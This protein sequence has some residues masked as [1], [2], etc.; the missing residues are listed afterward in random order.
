MHSFNI[1]PVKLIKALSMALE[2]AVNGMSSH[3][4]RTALISDRIAKQ[5][6]LNAMEHQRLLYAAL[7]HDIGA[8]S[9]WSE[10]RKIMETT[11]QGMH[12]HAEDGYLLLK[13]S[14]QLGD[15]AEPIRYHHDRWA[16]GNYS[17][18][19][20][21]KIPLISRI[22]HIADRV[23]VL[24]RHDEFIFNQSKHILEVIEKS[25]GI[26]FDPTLVAAVQEIA[27][28]ESFWLDLVNP[29]YYEV[30]FRSL[31]VYGAICY[32]LD[33]AI[34]IAEIFATIIDRMSSF[35]A[36][37]SHN[38][39]RIAAFLAKVK[40][41]S[42]D[43]VKNMKIAGLLHDLGKLAIPN[44]ILEKPGQLNKE[45]VVII[46]QHTYYTYRILQEI[47]GFDTIAKWAA[48]HHETLDGKGY[49]FRI[50]ADSLPLGSRILAVADI[51]VALTENRPYRDS[52]PEVRVR[53]IMTEMVAKGKIDQLVVDN[54][55]ASYQEALAIMHDEK[56]I[57]I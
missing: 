44:N 33:D 6:N 18:L 55:F 24:I 41:F 29:N 28:K 51:F 46:R 4:W 22:I 23:E 42:A 25:S 11:N 5:I 35:T 43:E 54:L 21:E 15:L 20:E 53:A 34:N 36:T 37:H 30:F 52:L 26:E 12:R 39:A 10:R 32:S 19:K 50:A 13:D 7:L 8:A 16:G 57:A 49:P 2:L 40:G 56:A 14:I 1:H 17:G 48:Y 47:D 27:K 38:V 45:E 3:H 9:S 31:D